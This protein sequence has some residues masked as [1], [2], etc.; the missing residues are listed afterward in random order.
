MSAFAKRVA[1]P[2]PALSRHRRRKGAD[3]VPNGQMFE[4]K[5]EH[6]GVQSALARSLWSMTQAP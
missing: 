1:A 2:Q 3:L 5:I 4:G 6:G